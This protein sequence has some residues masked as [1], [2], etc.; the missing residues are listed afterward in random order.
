MHVDQIALTECTSIRMDRCA[1]W[2]NSANTQF[3]E[4]GLDHLYCFK[5]A[6]DYTELFLASPSPILQ[7]PTDGF[8]CNFLLYKNYYIILYYINIIKNNVENLDLNQLVGTFV[9][10]V[11]NI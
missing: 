1:N 6:P 2:P 5:L 8:K 10:N 7:L 9:L 3:G 11:I 4:S